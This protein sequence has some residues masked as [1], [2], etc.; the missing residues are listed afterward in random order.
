VEAAGK[1][2]MQSWC[3]CYSDR[4]VLAWLERASLIEARGQWC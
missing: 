2:P 4:E 1:L 3:W